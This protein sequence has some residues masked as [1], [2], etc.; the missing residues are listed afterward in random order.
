MQLDGGEYQKLMDAYLYKKFKYKNIEPLGSHTGTNKVTKGIPDSYVKLDNEKY[1]LI[2]YGT[3]ESTSY[4]KIEKDIKSCLD[5]NKVNIDIN[6]IEEI[7]CCY[8]S[9]NI[10]LEQKKK[11]ENIK[12]DIKITL[13]GIGSVS[14]DLLIN[15]PTIAAEFLNIPIDTEQIFE[16]NEFIDR[17]DKNGMNAD[18]KYI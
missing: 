13:I 6:E 10:H 1:I 7:I 3:V 17:Y 8:T 5:R 14:H 15:Y 11:L 12:K 16:I 18:S 4:E 9:T 2:M